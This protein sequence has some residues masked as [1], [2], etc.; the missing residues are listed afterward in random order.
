MQLRACEHSAPARAPPAGR[1][2]QAAQ[3]LQLLLLQDYYV[4]V[5]YGW[6]AAVTVQ[7]RTRSAASASSAPQKGATWDL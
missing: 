1:A 3:D 5:Q 6:H 7:L 2:E 4:R